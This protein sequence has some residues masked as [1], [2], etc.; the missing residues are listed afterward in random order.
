LAIAVTAIGLFLEGGELEKYAVRGPV[1]VTIAI[2]TFSVTIR[3]AGL[4]IASFVTFMLA[5]TGSKEMRLVES[6]I[7]AVALTAFCV[8]LFAYALN[9]PFQLWPRF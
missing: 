2:L 6:L 4:I 3:P 5:S 1:L 8:F 9:L 7:A